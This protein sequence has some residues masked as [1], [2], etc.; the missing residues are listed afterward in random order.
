MKSTVKGMISVFLA[1]VLLLGAAPLTG[2][3]F[4]A[5]ATS[6]TA[7]EAIN[8][9]KSKLGQGLDMD[10]AYGCQCVDLILAYYDYLGVSRSSGNGGDYAWNTLPS[11]W[12]RLQGAQP[13]KGDILVY[14]GNDSNPYGHVAIYESDYSTYH[15]NFDNKSYVT[16]V[17]Y[18]RYNAINN[19]YWG[20][21]RPNWNEHTCTY[22]ASAKITKAPTRTATG[23]RVCTCSC[24][25]TRTQSI[26]AIPY[27]TTLAEGIYSI[28]TKVKSGACF[29]NNGGDNKNVYIYT[30]SGADLFWFFR[31]NSDGTYCIENAAYRGNYVT[32]QDMSMVSEGKLIVFQYTGGENQRFYVIPEGNY[33][34]LVAKHSYL[35]VD[36]YGANATDGTAVQQFADN[37]GDNQRW[38]ITLNNPTLSLSSSS[39]SVSAGSTKTVNCTIGRAYEC[40]LTPSVSNEAVCSVSWGSWNGWTRPL[41]ITG[42]SGGTATVTLTFKDKN[43]DIVYDTKTITVTVP[44]ATKPTASISATNNVAAS[45]TVT[46]SL[47]DNVGL[48]G[49]YWGTSSAY[50]G[51]AYTT[52]SGTSKNVTKTVSEA[53]TYYL[54]AKDSSG[55]VSAT[56]SQAFYQTAL[57][58]N[59]GSVSPAGMITMSGNSFS[60]PT[61]T[62]DGYTFKNWN[63]NAGGTGVSYPAGTSYKP[64]G[65]VTLYAQWQKN[66]ATLQSIAV[67]TNPT[68]T[69]YT[70]GDTLNTAGLTL[71]ATYSDNSTKTITSGFTCSPTK[72]DTAGFRTIAVTYGGKTTTFGV[73]VNNPAPTQGRVKSVSVNDVSINYKSSTTL[74]PTVTADE[75]VKYSVKY[76]SSNP[77]AVSVDNNGNV[78]GLKKGSATIT[79]TVTDQY[80][81]TVKDTCKVTVSY[82]VWQ[83]V[84]IILLFGWIWY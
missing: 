19:P 57:N 17:T 33:Y 15:Q 26:P 42:K 52:V 68:K 40:L 74:K 64:T 46:L 36:L 78:K 32:I 11:G 59:G 31:K 35:T 83:W 23:T 66:E 27:T 75:D 34:R 16:Q 8:W 81:N 65:N 37:G 72:L 24:G 55:N 53:G 41:N 5:N 28:A 61:P 58:A 2:V 77:N 73:T 30:G 29:A 6:R 76:E 10:G 79:C 1:V 84:I 51:N 13:Q 54:T 45:Q 4:K 44:D 60:L 21:I 49:Y 9:V 22:N 50:S 39:V 18:V 3:N 20:V 43:S 67:K 48:A 82:S 47:T 7:N 80:G 70:V 63:T 62:R 56:V 69:T 12:Q 38:A 14:S 25:N 71:T